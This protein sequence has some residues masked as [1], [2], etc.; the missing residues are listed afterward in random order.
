ML[1]LANTRCIALHPRVPYYCSTEMMLGEPQIFFNREG[2]LHEA[3]KR[4]EISK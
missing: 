1:V 2:K 3:E 4:Y